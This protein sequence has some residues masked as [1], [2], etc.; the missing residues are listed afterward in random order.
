MEKSGPRVGFYGPQPGLMGAR[1]T[2]LV[3]TFPGLSSDLSE[4]T[5]VTAAERGAGQGIG[6]C[7]SQSGDTKLTVA[8]RNG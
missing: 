6:C 7:S 4:V 2:A 3:F 8:G 1:I 5:R